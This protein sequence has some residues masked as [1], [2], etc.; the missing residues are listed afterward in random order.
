[1]KKRFIVIIA[2]AIAIIFIISLMIVKQSHNLTEKNSQNIETY[3]VNPNTSNLECEKRSIQS[4]EVIDQVN[5]VLQIILSTGPMNKS[6]RMPASTELTLLGTSV[7]GDTAYV[8]FD[9]NFN[10]LSDVDKI[11][12]K[13]SVTWSLTSISGINSVVFYVGDQVLYTGAQ[14]TESTN[15]NFDRSY[16]S[17][18]PTIDPQNSVLINLKLYYPDSTTNQLV[19]EQRTNVYANPNVT[20]EYYIVDELIKGTTD[21]DHYSA[22]PKSTKIINVE[23]DNRICY[24]NLSSDFVSKQPDDLETNT[25]AV[26]QIVNSLTMLDEVDAVQIFIDSKKVKGFKNGLDLSEVLTANEDLIYT[27]ED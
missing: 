17:I 13:A 14:G 22:I 25:L 7:N 24:V 1:M 18:D 6:L 11:Y 2:L 3:F 10:T 15:I 8:Y 21:E 5:E 27:P 9:E 4:V 19:E 12:V 20:K 26:Y 23:T 16:V